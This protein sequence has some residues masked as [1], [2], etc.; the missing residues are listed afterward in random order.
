MKIPNTLAQGFTIIELIVAIAILAI[1]MAIAIPSFTAFIQNNYAKSIAVNLVE[2]LIFAR[3]KAITI[4]SPVT[5][6]ATADNTFSSCGNQWTLGWLVFIDV[7][8]NGSLNSGTDTLLRTEALTG[9]NANIT[10][11]PSTSAATY[12]NLGFPNPNAANTTF[13]VSATG[14]TGNSVQNINIS[15]T[16]RVTATTSAC[17]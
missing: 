15:L 3:S 12:N 13:Q 17:P 7:N 6:C 1:V 4:N 9:Q 8:G 10:T 11:S 2:T 5:V 16:G 14:C